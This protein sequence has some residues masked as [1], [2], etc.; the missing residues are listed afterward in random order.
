LLLPQPPPLKLGTTRHVATMTVT[1]CAIPG[2]INSHPA[3]GRRGAFFLPTG[4]IPYYL[5]D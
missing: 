5:S 3:T 1:I 4:Q 2:H